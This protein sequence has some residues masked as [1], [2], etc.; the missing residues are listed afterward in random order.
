MVTP[1]PAWDVSERSQSDLHWERHL[2]NFLETSQ[3]RW[4]FSFRRFKYI[5]RKMS[6][7][8]VFKTSQ[9]HLEK[10]VFCVTIL[11][12]LHHISKKMSSL[13]RLWDVSKKSLTSICNFSKIPHKMILSDFHSVSGLI[14]SWEFWQVNDR[15][16]PIVGVL[17]TTFND[18]FWLIRL[19]VTCCHYELCWNTE[20][21]NTFLNRTQWGILN[22][23]QRRI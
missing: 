6:F 13:W 10:D 21:V 20:F 15:Q 9:K 3:R 18:F 1:Q 16:S 14:S 11:R 12:H 23:S 22:L 8:D 7:C 5:S 19:Y 17:F 4:L 2:R